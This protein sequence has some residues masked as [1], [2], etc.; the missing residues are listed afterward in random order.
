MAERMDD[1]DNQK[2]AHRSTPRGELV[3]PFTC[4]LSSM[5]GPGSHGANCYTDIYQGKQM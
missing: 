1:K 3:V 2:N 4:T 5:D